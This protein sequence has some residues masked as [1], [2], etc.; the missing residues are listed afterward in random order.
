MITAQ[1]LSKRYGPTTVVHD[2]SFSCEPGTITGFLGPNGAGKSTTLRMITGLTRPDRGTATIDGRAYA[3]LGNPSRVVGSLLD[4][5]AMHSGRSGRATLRI[6]ADLAGAGRGEVDRVLELVGLSGRAADRRVGA[7]SL[8]MRQRLGIGQALIARP[9]A[10]ILDEPANGLDPDGIAWMRT[11]LRDFAGS[12]GT[13]LLSSHLLGEVQ[14]T[15][16]RL[17]M[18]ASGRVVAHGTLDDLL[19][20]TGVVVRA[21]D[22]PALRT[23][24]DRVGATHHLH[25]DG[26]VLVEHD[27][28][29]DAER[30]A[31]L[32]S[33]AGVLLVEL[34]HSDRAGLEQLFFS[35]T[36]G[37]GS[38]QT[39]ETVR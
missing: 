2:V 6:A 39:L 1:E 33:Q 19:T 16:D 10:L 7:Y 23:M 3:E 25:D 24:L 38:P 35:L 18:I 37:A 30:I 15:V 36:G 20:S 28:D 11:L 5:S 26:A 12:G 34:R 4:A 22:M 13:V 8:G 17:V 9:R 27:D 14:A 21:T 32:A 29:L 31:R